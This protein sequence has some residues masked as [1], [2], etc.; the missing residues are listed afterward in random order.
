MVW[1]RTS[2]IRMSQSGSVGVRHPTS[3]LCVVVCLPK[4][5]FGV[6]YPSAS[7]QAIKD[8]LSASLLLIYQAPQG[9]RGVA[10]HAF[11]QTA[12]QQEWQDLEFFTC[13]EG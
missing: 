13:T 6:I 10:T 4:G 2:E 3:I 9:F 8:V 12:G 1:I 11:Y 7:L 5:V